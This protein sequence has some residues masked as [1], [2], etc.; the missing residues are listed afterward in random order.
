MRGKALRTRD[1]NPL[2]LYG[3][4]FFL[5]YVTLFQ[6]YRDTLS[7]AVRC[8]K[9]MDLQARNPALVQSPLHHSYRTFASFHSYGIFT[10]FSSPSNLLPHSSFVF[11]FVSNGQ[12][13]ECGNLN[14]LP[15]LPL[16]VWPWEDLGLISQACLNPTAITTCP[17]VKGQE[18]SLEPNYPPPDVYW[19]CSTKSPKG[20]HPPARH[21]NV[22]VCFCHPGTRVE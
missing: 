8:R 17:E 4:L 16:S 2:H 21:T 9:G 12:N 15:H 13:F 22:K 3:L 18:G 19:P 10:S 14:S 20:A 1:R 11:P 5:R 7:H 6:P